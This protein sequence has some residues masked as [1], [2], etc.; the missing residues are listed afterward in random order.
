MKI[1]DDLFDVTNIKLN[2]V[3]VLA[4]VKAFINIHLLKIQLVGVVLKI[5]S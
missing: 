2:F 4:L 5:F 3:P 1:L